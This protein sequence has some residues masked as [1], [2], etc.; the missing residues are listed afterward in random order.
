[1]GARNAAGWE[2]CLE[3]LD[4][5]LEGGSLANFVVD[6][7]RANFKCY[8]E[9]FEATVGPQ[10]GPPEDHPLL[11]EQADDELGELSR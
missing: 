11:V 7:W 5:L 4:L 6:V 3:T 2:L 1:M 10:R 8:V 9:K